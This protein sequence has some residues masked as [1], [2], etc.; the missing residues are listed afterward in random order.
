MY[1]ILLINTR[2]E[3]FSSVREDINIGINLL[4]VF[5]RDK[6]YNVALFRGSAHEAMEWIEEI[7]RKD[8]AKT[9]GFYCDY[10]N[11]TLVEEFSRKVKETW[12]IPVFTGG[13][14]AVGLG[15]DFF[16]KSHCDVVVRG[17][18]EFTLLDLL[19]VYIKN[20]K[21]LSEI[22]GISYIQEGKVVCR[23]DRKSV[24]DLDSLPWPDFRLEKNHKSWIYLPVMTGR[25][26]PYRCAFCYEGSNSKTVRFRSVENVM[27]EI[28][29][30]FE[31]H[32]QIKYIFFVDDTFTLDPK[33]VEKFCRELSRLR[34]ERDFI[35]FCE[36]HVQT[37]FKWP[38]MLEQMV[39]AGMVK[40]LLGIESGSDRVLELY[41]K[42][43]TAEMIKSVIKNCVKAGVAQIPGNIIIGGPVESNETLEADIDLINSLLHIAPGQ[44]DPFCFFLIPHIN[45]AIKLNPEEFGISLLPERELHSLEDIPLTETDSLDWKDMFNARLNFNKR[46]L[47]TMK[48]IYVKG[49]IPLETIIRCYQLLQK[50]SVYSI[51]I[52]NVFAVN[53]LD[54]LYYQYL[55]AGILK[56]SQ[57]I[58]GKSLLLCHP[59]RVFELWNTLSYD[60]GYPLIDK[61]VLSPVEYELLLLCSGKLPLIEII[62]RVYET[63]GDGF[64]TEGDFERFSL[65]ILKNFED[66]RWIGYSDF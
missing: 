58:K 48:K 18:G 21:K 19:D 25:G 63:S 49:K 41:R 4:A 46:I 29:S 32:P 38:E 35:W 44:F 61:Y 10:A 55:S 13:P 59:Q 57:D 2:R 65:E 36:G 17:D 26:C 66:R 47:T 12:N 16:R 45:T 62:K 40:I 34:K 8:G 7:M 60:R 56:H 9:T 39:E 23:P 42:N 20:E 6:G 54:H 33:R 27:K 24:E 5:L 15:E 53:P 1:D 28:C 50:Y 37:L 51:W 11:Q 30:H 3:H 31:R 22:D 52:P 43:T 14:Q 64:D